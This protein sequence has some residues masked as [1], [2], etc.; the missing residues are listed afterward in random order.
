M[1][2]TSPS[3]QLQL[4]SLEEYRRQRTVSDLYRRALSGPPFC[5]IAL[6]LT[7]L[8]GS[9]FQ[10]DAILIGVLLTALGV[11]GYLRWV[12]KPPA[13]TATNAENQRWWV[14]HWWLIHTTCIVWCVCFVVVG[15]QEREATTA[16][17]VATVA[18][19]TFTSVSGE[20]YSLSRMHAMIT[21]VLMQ[22]A[23]L[24]VFAV[25]LPALHG[26][27]IVLLFYMGYQALHIRRRA[28]E[29]DKQIHTE[30][31]LIT[32]RAEIDRL[33]R[34]DVLTGLS[35]RREYEAAFDSQWQLAQRQQGKLSLLVLDLDNF[36]RINDTHGHS[37]GDNCLK[38][39]AEVLRHRVRRSSD[40]VARIGGE[41]FVV[42]LPDTS[43]DEAMQLAQTVRNDI[44]TAPVTFHG[45]A[46]Q[47]T[48]SIGVGA[49]EWDLD[50]TPQ[51]SFSRVDAACYV[52]K[53]QG[54]N[55]VVQ[56]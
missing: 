8:T 27:A 17:L 55:R 48:T 50:L 16:F 18:T 42:L 34:Q 46:I 11:L 40:M 30:Y 51:A 24:V 37:A 36:K 14:G 1:K 20:T 10:A 13:D 38:H 44:A 35:N 43:N 26:V 23:A 49:M 31:T 54:R 19:I 21:V 25:S 3:P 2:P 5:A 47:V 45:K 6:V 39:V 32:S 9:H 53:V 52:A 4:P 22:A 41:E 29:Y 15:F 7:Q 12:H 56:A 33:S 28:D